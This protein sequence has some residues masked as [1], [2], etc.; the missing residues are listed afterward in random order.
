MSTPRKISYGVLVATLIAAAWLHLGTLL[1]AAFFAYFALRKLYA[2]TSRKWLA[3]MLFLVG[4]VAIAYGAGYFL[5]AAWRALPEIAE[6][7]IPSATAWAEKR[8]IE[9]PFTDFET[10]KAFVIE[11]LKDE[12]HYLSNVAHFA[13]AV[14]TVFALIVIGIVVAASLFFRTWR[15]P[16]ADSPPKDPNNL[17]SACA[18]EIAKRFED[19]YLSFET[20]MGAQIIISCINT[21]LTAIFILIVGLPHA[22][23]VIGVT[24][25]CGL[26]PIIG[27]LISNTIIV[28]LAASVSMKLAI[29]ALVFLIAIHKLEYFLNSKIIGGWTR[30]PVWLT[31]IGLIVGE[32]VLG[33]P[34][35]IL[36]PVV[37]NY[38]RLE[39]SQ[40]EVSAVSR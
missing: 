6:T 12:I 1:L 19:I 2:A 11:Q 17:Y 29:A 39:M 3:L 8:N 23:V 36:A 24:F 38:L 9:L 40:I 16:R 15:H 13:G 30:N 5:R 7:S 21:I 33:I 31:L 35:M 26:L 27:N 20:V 22:P 18:A 28:F 34:G 25:L 4:L 10:L 37:L 14:S 32:I